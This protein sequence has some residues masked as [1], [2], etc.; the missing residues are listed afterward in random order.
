MVVRYMAKW[1][2][3]MQ[4]LDANMEEPMDHAGR[5]SPQRT[6]PRGV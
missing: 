4:D 5:F 1:I 6:N 2:R 3:G